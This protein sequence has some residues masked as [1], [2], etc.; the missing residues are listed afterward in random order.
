MLAERPSLQFLIALTV[1]VVLKWHALFEP[2][3]WDTAMGLFPAALT[4]A[5]N[6]FNLV[7]LL[8]MPAFMQGG[9]NTHSTS[10][11]TLIS[12]LVL[13]ATGGGGLASFVV[14]HLLHF[15]VAAWALV[16]LFRFTKPVLGGASGAL[17]CLAVLLFPVFSAQV[18]Y[19]YLEIPLFL[20]AV[21]ALRAWTEQRFWPAV[22]WAT[23]AV[24]VRETGIIVVGT[25]LV[26]TLL[27]NRDVHQKVKRSAL[28][29]ASP[30]TLV[31]VL[32]L[33]YYWAESEPSHIGELLS[34]GDAFRSMWLH[35]ARI[36]F[37]VPDLWAFFVVFVAAVPVL[38]YGVLKTLGREPTAPDHRDSESR[39]NLVLGYSGILI[40][41]FIL[42]F[43]IAL[44]ALF[45]FPALLPRYSVVVAPFL[46]L[47]F[48]NVF[49]RLMA[50]RLASAMPVCFMILS[51]FFAVNANGVLYPMDVYTDTHVSDHALT[52]R[53]NAY[54]RLLALQVQ[55]IRAVTTLPDDV[56]VYYGHYEHYL[57]NYPGL[58]F[59]AA[60]LS[61]GRNLFLEPLDDVIREESRTPCIYALSSDP[62]LGGE[63]ILQLIAY[64][65]ARQNL[66]SEVIQEFRDGRYAIKLF[67][68]QR[69]GAVCPR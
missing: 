43:T 67:R 14:L 39:A 64:A 36:A 4:L 59:A 52:E 47:W 50:T 23:A 1:I 55:A 25:L 12:A 15:A 68:V 31:A 21:S 69:E 35:L 18:G 22:L 66:S 54:R 28:I 24:A 65:D 19:M 63:R 8:A 27:E 45:R 60:P 49:N 11:V 29:L 26:A 34:L 2:P 51:V 9:P 57:L 58:G 41:L 40:I 53:S 61:N 16:V 44:P 56:P 62:Y 37:K 17:F 7:E 48:G 6:N 42:T 3:V 38:G 30:T 10:V 20:C 32:L 46:L 33:L 13:R 5:D